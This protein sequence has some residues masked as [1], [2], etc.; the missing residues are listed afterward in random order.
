MEFKQSEKIKILDALFKNL[1]TEYKQEKTA[2]GK[3]AVLLK[4]FRVM[5]CIP[6]NFEDSDKARKKNKKRKKAPVKKE[7]EVDT[8]SEEKEAN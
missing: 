8:V 4:N 5:E 2:Y 7:V 3:Y 6:V 1:V